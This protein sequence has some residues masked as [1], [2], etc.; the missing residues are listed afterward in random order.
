MEKLTL[1]QAIIMTGVTGVL[2]CKFSDFHKDVEKRMDRP[3]FTHM[4]GDKDFAKDIKDL[5]REDFLKLIG[6]E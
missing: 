5:Y 2:C 6:E 4:F 3:V 1:E